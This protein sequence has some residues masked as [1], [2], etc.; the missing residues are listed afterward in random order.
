MTSG[1][2]TPPGMAGLIDRDRQ[3]RDCIT[4]PSETI[5]GRME[6]A[7]LV[8]HP[9]DDDLSP[10]VGEARDPSGEAA[11]EALFAI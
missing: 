5:C 3:W 7:R 2:E 9:A 1:G 6:S 8:R 4:E 10:A 11:N